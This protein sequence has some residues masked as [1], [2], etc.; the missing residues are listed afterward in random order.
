MD[1]DHRC[2]SRRLN[3]VV[4]APDGWV[5]RPGVAGRACQGAFELGE[6]VDDI[7]CFEDPVALSPDVALA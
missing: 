6:Q 4:S 1:A 3:G 2:M 5:A 7:G